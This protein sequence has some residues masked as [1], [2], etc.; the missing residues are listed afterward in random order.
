MPDSDPSSSNRQVSRRRTRAAASP[1]A[2]TCRCARANRS[3]WFPVIGPA[4]SARPASVAGVAIRVSA[5]TLAYDSR[6]AANSPRMTGRSRRA[7]A[8]RTCSRAVPEDIWHFHD[9]HAAQLVI[10]HDAQPRRAS[11]SASRTRNRHVAAARCPASSQICASSRSSGTPDG[12]A[13]DAAISAGGEAT[14][15]IEPD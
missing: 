3:S 7:R 15:K 13:E 4:I 14:A 1:A 2:V 5:R 10:S 6:P 8:T 11:K 12:P 9:S